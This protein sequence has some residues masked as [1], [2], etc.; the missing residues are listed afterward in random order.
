MKHRPHHT[1][2]DLRGAI[3]TP[4]RSRPARGGRAGNL[5]VFKEGEDE[6]Q[7]AKGD[8]REKDGKVKKHKAGRAVD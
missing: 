3:F 6:K 5:D 2:A 4:Q 8:E 1:F 7:Y